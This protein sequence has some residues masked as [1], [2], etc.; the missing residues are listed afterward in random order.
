MKV[1]AESSSTRTEWAV[2]D[3]DKIVE[4]AFT[5][6]LN[7][8]FQSRRE[9]SHSIRLE[10]PEAFFRRRWDHVYFYGAGCANKEK[11][12]IMESSLVAQFRT[13]V[14]VE[15]DLLGAARGLLVRQP[16]LACILGTG[17]NSCLYDGHEIVKNVP[18]LGYVL[19]DEGSNAY[20]GK[21]F[22]ADMLKGIAPKNLTQA[23]FE[24]YSVTHNMLMDEVYTNSL[25]S[26]ALA[27]YAAFLAEHVDNSYVYN[28]VYEGFTRFFA[29]NI[30]AYDYRNNPVCFVG[31]TA[32][33][34]R[35]ILER[36]ALDFGVKI[37]KII[38]NSLP[39][40]VEFH[41]ED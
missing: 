41:A 38:P 9:L 21:L 20:L 14:T 30:A 5:T 13:P 40:L 34:F 33:T 19:G 7:P 31:S 6:G 11:T 35:A 18:P 26:R 32:M 12:K 23:F 3:G 36:A 24:R 29:R 15:S 16:G 8:Y 2:V 22:I 17:S 27:K 4:H 37:S 1:I 28:L 10:L 25:P 39:G